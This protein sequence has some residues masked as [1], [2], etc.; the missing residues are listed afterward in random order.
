[1]TAWLIDLAQWGFLLYFAVINVAYLGLNLLAFVSV[2]RFM[3]RRALE[4]LPRSFSGLETPVSLIVPAYNEAVTIVSSVR[5]LLQLH[6]PQFEI[7]V[8]NDGSRDGTL[9]ELQ[10]AFSLVLVPE[11]FRIR[12]RTMPVRAV[13]RSRTHPE[14]RVID[15]ENGGKADALNAGINGARYPLFCALDADSILQRDSLQRVVLPFLEDPTTVASG[16]VVRL[17]NG[18]EVSDGFI[19]RPGVPR[20]P[21]ALVQVVEYLR[22][23]LF[24]R[25][26][27]SPLNA[28]LVISGAFGLF[29][30]ETVIVAGGY[31]T[32]TVGEDMDLVVRLHRMLRRDGRPY[33]IAFVPDP[34]C[35]TEAPERWRVLR[36][37][38]IR[39]QRGLS[40]SLAGNSDLLF[41]RWG[42]IPGWI[43]MPFAWI[44]EW[45]SP[46][47][48]VSGYVFFGI[49]LLLGIV[50]VEFAVAFLLMAVGLG[51]L[52][53]AMALLLDE[54]SFHTYPRVTD[55]LLLFAA[56]V[57]ENLGYRQ[58]IAWWRL[59]GLLQW[60]AGRQARWGE[61]TRT[62]S[63]QRGQAEA[64]R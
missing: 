36:S 2:S 18:C 16:G 9:A 28:V 24:G 61:M 33:R 58:A 3:Q 38:R 44:F 26:G 60:A 29:D 21:L 25:L 56:V 34:V 54:L 62:A 47:V 43:A 14:L 51:M 1:M 10:R 27:W 13:Y 37:Q 19:V 52:L 49:G 31:R 46:L 6:Y 57:I 17:A 15:K 12:L 32:D 48:E 8:V 42:G 45:A 63:W 55:L 41:G 39:W 23:F 40:E 20:N 53:S 4:H 30:K 11:A 35:W 59:R 50:S 7:V 5:S 64:R 22:A